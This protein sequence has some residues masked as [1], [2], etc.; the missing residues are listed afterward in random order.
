M[1]VCGRYGMRHQWTAELRRHVSFTLPRCSHSISAFLHRYPLLPSVRLFTRTATSAS[2]SASLSS[3]TYEFTAVEEKWREIWAAQQPAT[4][5]QQD[6]TD[7]ANKVSVTHQPAMRSHLDIPILLPRPS[8]STPLH[9]IVSLDV[10]YVCAVSLLLSVHVSLSVR[11]SPH[12]S[13]PSVHNQ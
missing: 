3:S 1:I 2:A 9:S 8:H 7:D 12:G 5:S 13:R 6:N 11:C 10:S 4:N